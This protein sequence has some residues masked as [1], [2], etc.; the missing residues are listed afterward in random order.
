MDC[1]DF[2]EDLHA[3][4]SRADAA[5]SARSNDRTVLAERDSRGH[6]DLTSPDRQVICSKLKPGSDDQESSAPLFT[7]CLHDGGNPARSTPSTFAHVRRELDRGERAA[8]E[9]S[10]AMP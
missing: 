3:R 10:G 6:L 5:V 8:A 7:G 4:R 1:L 9:V 2:R